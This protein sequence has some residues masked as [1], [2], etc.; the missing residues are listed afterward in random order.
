MTNLIAA[1]IK[2]SKAAVGF[3]ANSSSAPVEMVA[4]IKM[5]VV[6]FY[7]A[8]TGAMF[9]GN[10][11]WDIIIACLMGSFP[12]AVVGVFL[13]MFDVKNTV[14]WKWH[15]YF[16]RWVVNTFSG[17]L[18]G[19]AAYKWIYPT[20]FKDPNSAPSPILAIACGGAVGAVFLLLAQPLIPSI[21]RMRDRRA[22]KIIVG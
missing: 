14:D 17:A 19:P 13:N 20:I 16:L 21:R 7:L 9:R 18:L 10:E 8:T 11:E 4:C 2:M 12:G 3:Y 15:V 5:V 6:G 1:A 22:E